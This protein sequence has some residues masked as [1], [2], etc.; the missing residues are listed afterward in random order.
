MSELVYEHDESN[1]YRF[2][3]VE[4]GERNVICV[5]LNLSRA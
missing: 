5:E 4:F 3:L 1:K 2:V